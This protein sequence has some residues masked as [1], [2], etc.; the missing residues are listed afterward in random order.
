[1]GLLV[2]RVSCAHEALFIGRNWTGALKD[3][4]D[5]GLRGSGPEVTRSWEPS[6]AEDPGVKGAGFGEAWGKHAP[7]SRRSPDLGTFF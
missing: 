5:A 1:M 6:A 3:C 7:G 2:P 4:V